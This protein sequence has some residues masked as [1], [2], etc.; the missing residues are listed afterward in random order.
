LNFIESPLGE[1]TGISYGDSVIGGRWLPKT[2]TGSTGLCIRYD[3]T[4]VA[5]VLAVSSVSTRDGCDGNPLG[6]D[7]KFGFKG[8]R[9][10][11]GPSGLP[12]PG[13][14]GDPLMRSNSR[15]YEYVSWQS[16]GRQRVE[17]TW[18][19][20]HTLKEAQRF[21]EV[22]P[23]TGQAGWLATAIDYQYAPGSD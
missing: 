1:R 14:G 23:S 19:Y 13:D 10:Y 9:T 3:Y 4:A 21:V 20:L 16:D 8:N 7:W 2:I 18:T 15:G 22:D 5:G 12:Q 6:P 17:Q 11:A